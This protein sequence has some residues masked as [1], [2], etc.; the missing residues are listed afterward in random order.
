M[1]DTT[2]LAVGNA[3]SAYGD[4]CIETFACDTDE[5]HGVGV[6]FGFGTNRE[7]GVEIAVVAFV[8]EGDVDV[9][10]IAVVEWTLIRDAVADHFVDGAAMPR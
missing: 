4:G 2:D 1:N 7:G 6:R 9:E 8:E 10:D 3:G 5:F